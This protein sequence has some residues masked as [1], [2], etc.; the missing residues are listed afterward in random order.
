MD[1]KYLVR[2]FV[3]VLLNRR[4][5]FPYHVH[6]ENTHVCNYACKMCPRD[7]FLKKEEIRSIDLETYKKIIEKCVGIPLFTLAG[8]G[9]PLCDPHFFELVDHL[10]RLHPNAWIR[11][12][13]NGF[14]LSEENC[15]K[16]ALSDVSEIQI[17]ID[18]LEYTDESL[19][20]P[21]NNIE[22]KLL[23]LSCSY[24]NQNKVPPLVISMVMTH[25]TYGS[26]DQM[27]KLACD[28]KAQYIN[29]TRM[30]YVLGGGQK[31]PDRTMEGKIYSRAAE[32]SKRYQMPIRLKNKFNVAM[33]IA[34]VNSRNC[35]LVSD[36]MYVT[37][38][39][40]VAPCCVLRNVTLGDILKEPLEAIWTPERFAQFSG[41]RRELCKNCDHIFEYQNGQ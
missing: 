13:T 15:R 38:D 22:S 35:P 28:I 23:N 29:I 4:S 32:L 17:S 26:L 8:F 18:S 39:G 27:F 34:T 19:G 9:E 14:F 11:I 24:L 41:K 33:K 2:K 1:I 5:K 6:I 16:F 20:H 31:R 30:D 21:I 12:I 25:D 10:N 3:H 40:K 37:I 36:Y 7:K